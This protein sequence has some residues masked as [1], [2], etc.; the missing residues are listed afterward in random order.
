ML[1]H[2]QYGVYTNAGQDD[3]HLRYRVD[4]L[5]ARDLAILR[6]MVESILASSRTSCMVSSEQGS[7]PRY[8]GTLYEGVE[9]RLSAGECLKQQSHVRRNDNN[10]AELNYVRT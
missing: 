6:S 10:S 4:F 3:K 8:I 2:V 1:R 5:L 7:L 9:G